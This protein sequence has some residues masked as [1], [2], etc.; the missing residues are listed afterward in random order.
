M[1]RYE[2]LR[3]A[4]LAEGLIE[5]KPFSFYYGSNSEEMLFIAP[6]DPDG[7]IE[8]SFTLNNFSGWDPA[9]ARRIDQRLSMMLD[10]RPY[11][12]ED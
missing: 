12:A 10:R 2:I 11:F 8:L 7:M 1:I 9:M 4:M 6:P 5:R 3:Q